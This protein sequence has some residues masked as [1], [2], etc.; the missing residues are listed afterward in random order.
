MLKGKTSFSIEE[1]PLAITFFKG[2]EIPEASV[3]VW[4]N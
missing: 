3:F 2:L 1:R 4:V